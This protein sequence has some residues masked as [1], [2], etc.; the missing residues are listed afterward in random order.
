MIRLSFVSYNRR[1]N[2]V[3]HFERFD[4]LI[5]HVDF[6][7]WEPIIPVSEGFMFCIFENQVLNNSSSK[8]FSKQLHDSNSQKEN[9]ES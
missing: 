3:W 1:E 6:H 8:I 5:C 9:K 2:C 7:C 4:H